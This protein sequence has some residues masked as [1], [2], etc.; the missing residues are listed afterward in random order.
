MDVELRTG[1]PLYR[2]KTCCSTLPWLLVDKLPVERSVRVGE[3]WTD[4][5]PRAARRHPL[6]EGL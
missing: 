4:A 6:G 2:T 1:E 3:G 5:T